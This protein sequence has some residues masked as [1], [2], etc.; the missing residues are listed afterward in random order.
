MPS[1]GYVWIERAL[2]TLRPRWAR[3]RRGRPTG[4]VRRPARRTERRMSAFPNQ[5]GHSMRSGFIVRIAFAVVATTI[6]AGCGGGS[7]NDGQPAPGASSVIATP[8]PTPTAT[9][10]A[11]PLASGE[12]IVFDR[13]IA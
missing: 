4:F 9:P 3:P 2:A 5:A 6:V 10:T 7:G 8:T 1:L 12:L 13:L 11:T